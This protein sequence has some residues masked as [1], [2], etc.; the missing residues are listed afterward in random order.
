M[1]NEKGLQPDRISYNTIIA[2]AAN[3]FGDAALRRKSL[4][5]GLAAYKG[6]ETIAKEADESGD[7]FLLP[8]SLSF[9]FFFRM[10]RKCG[11]SLSETDRQSWMR[12]AF[13]ACCRYGCLNSKIWE[14]L[15]QQ[16]PPKQMIAQYL[17]AADGGVPSSKKVDFATLPPE[18]S[19]RAMVFKNGSR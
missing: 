10:I 14:E 18:W 16:T 2:A 4:D 7:T 3:A 1:Q 17:G 8:T 13:T 6:L 12:R 5:I 11:A 15:V 9:S 19:A